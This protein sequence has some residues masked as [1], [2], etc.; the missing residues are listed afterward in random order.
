[1]IQASICDLADAGFIM[2]DWDTDE[3]VIRSFIKHDAGINNPRRLAAITN[4]VHEISSPGLRTALLDLYPEVW[5]PDPPEIRDSF[6]TRSTNETRTRSKPNQQALTVNREQQQR[7]DLPEP[8]AAA[9]DIYVSHRLATER[10]IRS[11]QRYGEHIRQKEMASHLDALLR[12]ADDDSPRDIAG[13]VL[14]M[15]SDQIIQGMAALQ[16]STT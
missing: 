16:R 10:D 3:I 15:T 2:V 9:L 8:A 6:D 12:V 13:R 4:A 14:G 5:P 7:A 11:P 1:M